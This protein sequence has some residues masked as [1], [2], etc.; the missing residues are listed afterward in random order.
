MPP[1]RIAADPNEAAPDAACEA[2]IA[3]ADAENKAKI[4][5][6]IDENL[7]DPWVQESMSEKRIGDGPYDAV[8]FD[9]KFAEKLTQHKVVK[10]RAMN[11]FALDLK[12]WVSKSR[13][14]NLKH[15]ESVG[16]D[17]FGVLF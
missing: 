4:I 6:I 10:G 12:T 14:P 8:T 17:L 16:E 3:E 13:V 5:T 15:C 1:K 7:A 2:L 11:L 9:A